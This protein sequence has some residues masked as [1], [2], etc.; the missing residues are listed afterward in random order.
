MSPALRVASKEIR[1]IWEGDQCEGDHPSMACSAQELA[2][3]RYPMESIVLPEDLEASLNGRQFDIISHDPLHVRP[4]VDETIKALCRLLNPCGVLVIH[5]CYPEDENLTSVVCPQGAWMGET[6]K[7]FA[8]F[9]RHNL[10]RSLTIDV[11][12]RDGIIFN[13]DLVLDFDDH[14]DISFTDFSA[15]RVQACGLTGW[16]D[17]NR[18]LTER[19]GVFAG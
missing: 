3:S 11:D 12:Y 19:S 18:I 16:D 1:Y 10:S 15:N 5:D 6:Y 17:F 7:A 4:I 2:G 8:N 13:R 9:H 14:Y